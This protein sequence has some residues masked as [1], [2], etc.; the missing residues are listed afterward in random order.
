VAS[1]ADIVLAVHLIVVVFI[2]GG[3]LAI[4]LGAALGWR[5]VRTFW[6]RL[7]HLAAIGCIALQTLLGRACPLTMWEDYLRGA[8]TEAGFVERWLERLIYFDWPPWVF[9][10]LH[11]GFAVL[12]LATWWLVP[13]RRN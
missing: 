3:L 2:G 12:V 8:S 4:W 9:T 10:L 11:V 5:W 6:L 1:L 13:P 7:A